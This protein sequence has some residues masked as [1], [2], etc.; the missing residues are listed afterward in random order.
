MGG[1]KQI[2]RSYHFADEKIKSV[3]KR[4]ENVNKKNAGR[5]GKRTKIAWRKDKKR[6]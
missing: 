2:W 3:D 4:K 1:L 6:G 5:T